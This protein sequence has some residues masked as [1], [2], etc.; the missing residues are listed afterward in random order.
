MVTDK[1][2]IIDYV[3]LSTHVIAVAVEGDA[4]TDWA[5]YIDAVPGCKHVNELQGVA[6]TGEKLPYEVAKVLFGWVAEKYTWRK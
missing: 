1:R 5:A 2:K 6:E 4:G 3:A